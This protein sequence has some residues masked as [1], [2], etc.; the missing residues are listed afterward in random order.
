LRYGD[1]PSLWSNIAWYIAT[2]FHIPEMLLDEYKNRQYPL[3]KKASI[4]WEAFGKCSKDVKGKTGAVISNTPN[5]L[6]VQGDLYPEGKGEI[7]HE[8]HENWALGFRTANTMAYHSFPI[9]FHYAVSSQ[10]NNMADV[11]NVTVG[12][13]FRKTPEEWEI[14]SKGER[15][16]SQ[17]NHEGHVDVS[18]KDKTINFSGHYFPQ[19]SIFPVNELSVNTFYPIHFGKPDQVSLNGII[20]KDKDIQLEANETVCRI[21]DN[22]FIYEISYKLPEQAEILLYRWCNFLR[23][24]VFFYRGK[25]KLFSST[26]LTQ[27]SFKGC[28]KIL[29]TN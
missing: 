13:M 11:R 6:P 25:E 26:E 10:V 9:H 29:K 8:Q 14:D 20:Y 2:K 17:F 27:T 21:E 4:R 28:F 16:E 23:F 19:D 15:N 1:N 12:V 18:K 3:T 7:F 22:G 5:Y 24:S